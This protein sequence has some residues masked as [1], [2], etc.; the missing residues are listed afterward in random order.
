MS[1]TQETPKP[2]VIS[3]SKLAHIVLC[4]AQFQPMFSYHKTFLGATVAFSNNELA[5]LR[6]DSEHHRIAIAALPNTGPKD[7]SSSGLWH[8]A[9]TFSLSDLLTAYSQRKGHGILPSWCVNHGPTTS[10]YYLDP[11]G[12]QIETQ[13]DNFG[14]PEDADGYMRSGSYEENP[15]GVEFDPEELIWMLGKGVGVEE[16]MRRIDV[17]PR[18][19]GDIPRELLAAYEV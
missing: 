5:F 1:T 7:P 4:T 14:C 11:D 15:I 10:M 13:I 6:Y 9:F 18:D 2:K 19:F 3:P 16:I 8:F 17:G 12:N